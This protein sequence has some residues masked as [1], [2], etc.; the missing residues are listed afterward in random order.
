[1]SDDYKPRPKAADDVETIYENIQRLKRER[2]EAL[3]PPCDVEPSG[4]VSREMFVAAMGR[5]PE[6]DDLERANC[7]DAGKVGHFMCG[8]DKAANLPV[9]EAAA[10]RG[11]AGY[12]AAPPAVQESMMR[13]AVRRMLGT[14]KWGA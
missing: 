5:G 10:R 13:T 1:M 7:P 6:Q 12:L 4:L 11:W 2:E 9:V 3:Q 8:W 14:E